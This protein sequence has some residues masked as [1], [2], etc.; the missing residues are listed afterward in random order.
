MKEAYIYAATLGSLFLVSSYFNVVAQYKISIVS[1][2]IR[3]GLTYTIIKK[4]LSLPSYSV[5]KA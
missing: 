1:S 4:T 2:C 5:K 3:Y